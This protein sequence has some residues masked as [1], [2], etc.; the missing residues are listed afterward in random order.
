MKTGVKVAVQ[1]AAQKSPKLHGV[2]GASTRKIEEVLTAEHETKVTE[3]SMALKLSE[4]RYKVT[5]MQGSCW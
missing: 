5:A 2:L 4:I 3:I 1:Q